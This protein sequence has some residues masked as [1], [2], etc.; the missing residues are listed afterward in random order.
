M[1]HIIVL[2]GAPATGKTTLA[3][4][5]RSDDLKI[6]WLK[7]DAFKDIF[8]RETEKNLHLVNGLGIT[9]LTHLLNLGYS[10]VV[11]GIFQDTSRIDEIQTL[12]RER[13]IPCTVFQLQTEYQTLQT[14]DLEREKESLGLRKRLSEETL[15]RLFDK[16]AG[17]VYPGAILLDTENKTVSECL[18]F[19]NSHLKS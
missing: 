8:E 9:T 17:S 18:A 10:V 4:A 7:I 1:Q 11:D 15:K 13:T 12:A 2:R 16:V 14:R 3:K 19:I 5:M 6:A